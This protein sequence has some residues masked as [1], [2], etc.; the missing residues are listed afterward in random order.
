MKQLCLLLI[1]SL[2][3]LGV[4]AQKKAEASH[5]VQCVI[6]D[7][8]VMSLQDNNNTSDTSSGLKRLVINS[9]F[10]FN[11]VV[12]EKY[13]GP[14]FTFA[15]NSMQLE[16]ETHGPAAA[17]MTGVKRL[18]YYRM[19]EEYQRIALLYTIAQF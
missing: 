6:G 15:P 4:Q 7:F 13:T 11:V 18:K 14:S 1:S 16:E 10:T 19:R 17:Q 2:G 5:T 3:F 9:N 12:D 8:I